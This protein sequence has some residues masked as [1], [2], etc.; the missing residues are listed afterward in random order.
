MKA[1]TIYQPWA[2]AIAYL[3]KRIENRTWAPPISSLGRRIA[4]HAGKTIQPEVVEWLILDGF[5]EDDFQPQDLTRGAV[6]A[7]AT[8]ESW[9]TDGKQVPDDQRY[10]WNGPVGWL[11]KDVV[12]IEPVPCRGA[13]GLW[14]LPADVERQVSEALNDGDEPTGEPLFDA[15]GKPTF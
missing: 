5:L 6:V 8:L 12:P 13:Q 15:D 4:I 11:L 9:I 7:L 14:D 3:G 1:L 2:H 10:W